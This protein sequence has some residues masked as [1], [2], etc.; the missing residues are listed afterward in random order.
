MKTEEFCKFIW[1]LRESANISRPAMEKKWPWHRNTIM[2]YEKESRLPDVDYLYALSVETG[3]D[4]Y[5]LVKMRLSAGLLQLHDEFVQPGIPTDIVATALKTDTFIYYDASDD[6]MAPT[7]L[8]NASM[9]IEPAD[10]TLKQGCIYAL[11]LNAEVVPRRVQYGLNSDLSL[12]ADNNIYLPILVAP[13]E[14][15]NIII[16]GKVNSTT[17]PL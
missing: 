17:N 2:S 10:K 12:V 16:I 7:I 3:H 9:S 8:K 1:N 11:K 5:D 13:A 14:R 15:K 4:F 6:S